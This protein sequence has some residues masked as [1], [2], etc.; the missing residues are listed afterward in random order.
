MSIANTFAPAPAFQAFFEKTPIIAY[1]VDRDM[2]LVAA[3]DAL[4]TEIGFSR[5]SIEGRD[6]FDVFPANPADVGGDGVDVLRS[7]LER[8][9][10]TGIAEKLPRQRYDVRSD[11]EAPFEERYWLPENVP[12]KGARG[13]VQYVIHS[14][15]ASK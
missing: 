14:V 8:A 10:K 13:D 5:E 3:T 11:A 12:V 1:V 7:S 4:L 15:V 2:R 9:F 6:V